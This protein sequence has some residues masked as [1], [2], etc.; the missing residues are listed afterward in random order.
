MVNVTTQERKDEIFDMVERGVTK[1]LKCTHRKPGI[2]T[3]KIPGLCM[4][5]S[6]VGGTILRE[7]GFTPKVQGGTMTWPCG[8]D[9][10]GPLY[11]SYMWNEVEAGRWIIAGVP[12]PEIHSWLSVDGEVVDF[13]TRHLPFACKETAGLE[14]TEPHPPRYMWMTEDDLPERVVYKSYPKAENQVM[15]ITS[16]MYR[17]HAKAFS[18]G[19]EAARR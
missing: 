9:A 3:S 14:W 16:N 4:Y 8:K 15:H 13:C 1:T 12:V 10:E 19:M 18:L 2:T 11:F 6:L 7:L 5:Y 17:W